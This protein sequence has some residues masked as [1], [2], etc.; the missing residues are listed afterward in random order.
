MSDRISRLLFAVVL[1]VCQF[2]L[3]LHKADFALHADGKECSICLAAHA[4]DHP[5]SASFTP[6]ILEVAT[7]S[8]VILP[9][10]FT[11]CRAPVRRVARSPPVAPLHA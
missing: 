6:P 5:L 1:L 9:V 11:A 8:P 3:T 10:S 7:E 4:L 2:A